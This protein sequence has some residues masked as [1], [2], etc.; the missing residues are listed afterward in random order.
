MWAVMY[1][2]EVATMQHPRLRVYKLYIS[3]NKITRYA[4]RA[5]SF[6]MGIS[7]YAIADF[8]FRQ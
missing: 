1:A 3:K 5:Y 7:G 2:E 4:G 8:F 6:L